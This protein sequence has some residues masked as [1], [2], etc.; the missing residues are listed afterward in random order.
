MTLSGPWIFLAFLGLVA[1]VRL[2]ELV[3]S[4]RNQAHHGSRA[5]VVRERI[6]FWMVVLHASQ[7]VL[8]PL[9]LFWRRPDFGGVV[10]FAAIGLFVFAQVMRVWTLRTLGKSWNVRVLQSEDYPIVTSGPYRWIRHPNY[11]IVIVEIAAIPLIYHLYASALILS[12]A[13]ALVL[14]VRIGNEEAALMQNPAWA[15]GMAHKPRFFPFMSA[16]R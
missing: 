4:K 7:F 16:P 10:S 1:L 8:L 5:Q 11:A 14:R 6:F 15:Q 3:L 2:G 13:N 12:V 9:E